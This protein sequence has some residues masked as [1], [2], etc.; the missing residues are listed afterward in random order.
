M[1]KLL[2]ARRREQ[3]ERLEI[4]RA[5]ADRIARVLGRASALAYGSVVRGDFHRGSDIDILV[6]SDALPEGVLERL[7]VLYS[8]ATGREEPKGYRLAEFERMR[9]RRHPTIVAALEAGQVLRDDLDLFGEL[10]VRV[11]QAG[12]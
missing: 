8:V 11:G 10:R 4:A 12:S 3:Q 2:E 7:G 6:I 5:Y 9:A 1:Y